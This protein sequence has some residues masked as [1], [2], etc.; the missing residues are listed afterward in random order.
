M[1]SCLFSLILVLVVG[2]QNL[3]SYY[4]P[5]RRAFPPLCYK[6][7]NDPSQK[8]TGTWM[9][10]CTRK[11]IYDVIDYLELIPTP[12]RSDCA[13]CPNCTGIALRQYLQSSLPSEH[14]N[15]ERQ[16]LLIHRAVKENNYKD[17][18]LWSGYGP[19]LVN[20][21][22]YSWDGGYF[23]KWNHKYFP[24]FQ[25]VLKYN[26]ENP[27]C[28]CLWHE[29]NLGACRINDHVFHFLKS[30]ADNDLI[31]P[32]FSPYWVAKGLAFRD[33]KKRGEFEGE[34][35]P[36]SGG[37]ASSLMTYAF[38]YS[39][40]HQILLD[41]A[42]FIDSQSIGNT[43][44]AL[45]DIYLTLD[46]I[47][48]DFLVL[49]N[50]CLY[51]HPHPKIHYERGLLHMHDGRIEK[52]LEDISTLMKLANSN[53][54]ID[55]DILISEMY[56]QEGE[57]YADIGMY[58]KAISSLTQAIKLDSTNKE[59]YFQRA[60]AYFETGSFDLALNDYIASGQ[61]KNRPPVR[62]QTSKEFSN[63]FMRGLAKGS[64]DSVVD[65]FPSLFSAV[66]QLAV[67]PVDSATS[68]ANTSWDLM[69]A[70]KEYL[71]EIDWS[72]M[73][74]PDEDM[75]LTTTGA[76]Y[77]PALQMLY[78]KFDGL[79]DAEKGEL[80]GYA[81]GHF[82]IDFV[83]GGAILKG[84]KFG[85]TCTR[86]RE[87][88]KFFALDSLAI[89]A[90][91]VEAMGIAAAQRITL[92]ETLFQGAKTGHIVAKTPNVKFHVMQQ[93][94]A[95]DRLVNLTGNMEIDFQR[96][97]RL[98]EEHHILNPANIKSTPKK[99]PMNNPVIIRTDYEMIIHGHK[100]EAFFD[101][102][103]ETGELFFNDAWIVTK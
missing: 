92:R 37:M 75:F 15:A 6:H 47:R 25:H 98:L 43:S 74:A 100:I 57:A 73:E 60:A 44:K 93:K 33:S 72:R 85:V 59:A 53:Q 89:S 36:H 87:A 79:T 18:C 76:F 94:H 52:A 42:T 84:A 81:I 31:T 23:R 61:G 10:P 21:N 71:N 78:A 82:G 7:F 51:H 39:Q 101:T 17:C 91:N 8:T 95:W 4:D 24:F 103:I 50:D 63:A 54:F 40:Y 70:T 22:Q 99:F 66:Y 55:E 96:V 69:L 48:K 56:Q 64:K 16:I 27:E 5:D 12:F 80:L 77:E 83:A 13:T 14:S 3:F 32:S 45:D 86:V 97:V 20:C 26:S 46:K 29:D 65:F 102:C 49:Y 35:Y 19:C 41:V 90:A 58:D 28:S 38:F 11:F 68:L 30:L 34:Y 1:K 88:N 62:A 2:F 67:H 9:E